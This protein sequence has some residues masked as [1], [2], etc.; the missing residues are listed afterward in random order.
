M[1]ELIIFSIVIVSVVFIYI[2]I[3]DKLS[4]KDKIKMDLLKDRK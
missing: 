2:Y 4:Q 3:S 1:I